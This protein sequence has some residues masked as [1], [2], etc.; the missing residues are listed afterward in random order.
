MT[1]AALREA[2]IE[3]ARQGLAS[4]RKRSRRNR[5]YVDDP[6]F[7]MLLRIVGPCR[8]MVEEVERG[9]IDTATALTGFLDDGHRE[10]DLRDV[11]KAREFLTQFLEAAQAPAH[12]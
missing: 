9:G 8:A 7:R 1:I 10:R 6:A 4:G 5:H 3:A 11:A 2:V 12:P